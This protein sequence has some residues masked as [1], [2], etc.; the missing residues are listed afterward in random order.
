VR[1]HIAAA[2]VVGACLVAACGSTVPSSQRRVAG[3]GDEGSATAPSP[4]QGSAAGAGSSATEPSGAAAG[5]RTAARSGP[6]GATGTTVARVTGSHTPVEIGIGVDSNLAAFAAA[7]GASTS[8]PEEKIVAEAIVADINKSGGLGGHP[9]VPVFTEFDS[10]S[11]DWVAEDEAACATFTQ[12]H[13]VVAAVRT[14]DIFGPLDA[15]LAHAGVPLVLYESVFRAPSWFRE[16][17]G[18]RFTPDDPAPERLYAALVDRLVA[19]KQ[20]TPATKIGLVRYDRN[21]QAEI[22]ARAVRPAMAARG[23]PLTAAEAVHTPESFQD[24]GASSSQL[25]GVI[26]R[27]RSLGI[28]HVIF[29]G[30]D[31]SFLFAT[32][33]QSQSYTPKYALTSFDFP[34]AMPADQLHGAYGVGWQPTDDI[35]SPQPTPSG[36]RHCQQAAA[37]LKADFAAAGADRLYI[38]CDQLF[39][40]KA[41]YDAAG[42]VGGDALAVG[43]KRLGATWPPAFTFAVNTA[44]RPDGVAAV[45][46]LSFEE[47]CACL[48]YGIQ[49]AL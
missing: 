8:Q 30:G 26:L 14:D 19:T 32:A 3:F 18:L 43:A 33:A 20:W 40:L 37:G 9:L 25:P 34:N 2:V 45:R 12:D 1:P 4:D 6:A 22:E 35:V 27:F 17:P 24:V 16:V 44:A 15:C 36:A 48:V 28:D 29:Q 10:T 49:S 31:L 41:A 11:S 23:I 38:T 7:F 5:G 21:D 13:H 42:Y 47:G 46:D 39:F